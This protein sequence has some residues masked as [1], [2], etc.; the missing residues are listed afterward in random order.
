MA[1]ATRPAVGADGQSLA[2]RQRPGDV[3]QVEVLLEVGG[4]LSMVGDKDKKVHALK[5]SV[6][7]SMVY[8]EKRLPPG[9][10]DAGEVRAA[11]QYRRCDAVIKID[12]GGARP[13]LR[14]DRRLVSVVGGAGRTTMF[15]PVNPLSREELDLIEIPASSLL[16]E[17]L[18]PDRP[19]SPGDEWQHSNDS[20]AALLNLD[21]VSESDVRSRFKEATAT[22]A[23]LELAGTVHGA[24]EG[25]STEIELKGRY[26]FDLATRRITW[27]ALL[28]KE[29]RPIGHVAPGVDVVARL[30]MKITPKVTSDALS[31]GALAGV[32]LEPR[33]ESTLLEYESA[34]GGFRFLHD[35]GWHVV[36]EA[37][38]SVV[39]RLVDRGE[40]VAQCNVT[41]LAPVEA[42]KRLTLAKFQE[43]VERSL[44]KTFGRF[45]SARE[46]VTAAGHYLCRVITTGEVEK[47]PIQWNYYLVADGRGHQVVAAFT[48]ESALVDRFGTSDASI[49]ATLRFLAESADTAARPTVAPVRK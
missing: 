33:P 23:Q 6:V 7:G 39:L 40:L 15:S 17:Q 48:L 30:Q 46:S 41:A 9:G 20:V 25:V 49:L 3:S 45:E 38:D 5:M 27:V 16:V 1:A 32:I 12:K 43:D 4:D 2:P 18:L 44:G 47:L 34:Q 28:I 21:A 8:D 13:R 42:G 29:K 10:Q 31:D 35:R 14:D 26:K 22:A 37:R 19:V 11:R 36:N 24:A